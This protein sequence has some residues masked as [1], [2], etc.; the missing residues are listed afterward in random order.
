[1][2]QAEEL[3]RRLMDEI[4]CAEGCSCLTP[5]VRLAENAIERVAELE[6]AIRLLVN[7]HDCG[8]LMGEADGWIALRSTMKRQ[9]ASAE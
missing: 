6:A 1:M 2:S 8:D 7:S 4:G 5:A 9:K 3:N